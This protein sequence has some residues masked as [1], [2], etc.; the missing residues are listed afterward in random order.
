MSYSIFFAGVAFA[1]GMLIGIMIGAETAEKQAINN[2][3]SGQ[4]IIV[5]N[6]SYSIY[7]KT[8]R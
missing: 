5:T 1:I 4:W 6:S 8:L 7:N 2:I 3:G